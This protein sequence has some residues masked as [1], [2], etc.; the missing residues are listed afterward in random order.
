MFGLRQLSLACQVKKPILLHE[1]GAHSDMLSILNKFKGQLPTIVLHSFVGTSE[2]ASAYL[3]LDN[4]YIAV[5]GL[6][7]IFFRV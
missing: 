2:E 6:C 4:T 5:S 7:G 1:R 3:E